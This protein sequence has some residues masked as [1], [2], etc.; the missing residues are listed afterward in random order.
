MRWKEED[1]EGGGG[2]GEALFAHVVNEEY[3]F[4]ILRYIIYICINICIYIRK[5]QIEGGRKGG[6]SEEIAVGSCPKKFENY[7]DMKKLTYK[8]DNIILI[9]ISIYIIITE[10]EGSRGG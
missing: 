7:I 10:S 8:S 5:R 3:T 2:E 6:K 1:E 9:S 4:H